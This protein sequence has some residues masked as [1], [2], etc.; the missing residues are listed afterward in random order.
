MKCK[1]S[2]LSSALPSV[3]KK[4]DM[5]LEP[6]L[7]VTC[8]GTPCLEKTS[9]MKSLAS[10]AAVMVSCVG[11]K[12]LCFD[13]QSTMTSMVLKPEDRGSSSMKSMEMEFQGCSGIRSWFKSVDRVGDVVV[14]IT[15]RW[16]RTGS[17]LEQRCGGVAKC[18]HYGQV[19]ESY[20]GQSVWR[21]DGHVC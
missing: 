15:Y 8:E 18:S 4:A 7:D 17:S 1:C 3:Q 20:S 21:S 19:E 12:M 14:W 9:M 10:S 13:S 5:N 16:F 11:M 6:Q 2:F